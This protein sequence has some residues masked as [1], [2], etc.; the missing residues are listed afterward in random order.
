MDRGQKLFAVAGI[1]DHCAAVGQRCVAGILDFE[2]GGSRI[3]KANP[4][5]FLPSDFSSA[6]KAVFAKAGGIQLPV[7]KEL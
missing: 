3:P 6:P 2:D 5:H 4:G 7:D 1:R